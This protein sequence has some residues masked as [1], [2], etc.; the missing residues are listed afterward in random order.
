MTH[1]PVLVECGCGR[2]Y[3]RQMWDALPF[4]GIQRWAG[5]AELIDRK[6]ACG[7]TISV[8][9]SRLLLDEVTITERDRD[10]VRRK[11]AEHLAKKRSHRAA[12]RVLAAATA[13]LSLVAVMS[14]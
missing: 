9:V 11:A 5:L 3:S 10:E 7:T 6:C 4:V 12:R 13:L 1:A 14:L 2:R 8:R